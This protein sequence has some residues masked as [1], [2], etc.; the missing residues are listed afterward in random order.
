MEVFFFVC[1]FGII[2]VLFGFG[3]VGELV[4][5]SLFYLIFDWVGVKDEVVIYFILFII[6]FMMIIVLYFV[7]GEQVLKIYV[8]CELERMLFWC[9]VLM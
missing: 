3:W 9:V 8:I 4:F 2:M 1:Q 5:V 7:I 6:V